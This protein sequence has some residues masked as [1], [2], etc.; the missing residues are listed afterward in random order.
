MLCHNGTLDNFSELRQELIDGGV[1]LHSETDSELIA[2][3]LALELRNDESLTAFEGIKKIIA[4]KLQGY[5]SFCAIYLKI[6]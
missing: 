4:N 3:L 5:D 6:N 1:E 2:Q